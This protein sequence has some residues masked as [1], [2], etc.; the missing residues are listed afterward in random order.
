VFA[1]PEVGV[2]GLTEPQALEKY[3]PENIK[4]YKTKFTAMYYAM[5]ERKGPTAYKLICLGPEEKVIGLHIIGIGSAE[6]LQGFGVAVKMGA[7]KQVRLSPPEDVRVP[8]EQV[9]MVLDRISIIALLFTLLVP[10]N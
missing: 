2:I 10:R 7:T 1:H 5:L 9:L 3:G 4:I 8:G 6:M